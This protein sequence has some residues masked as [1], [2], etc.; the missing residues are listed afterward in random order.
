M[1]RLKG[2]VGL[3]AWGFFLRTFMRNRWCPPPL[4]K[5]D[6]GLTDD[7]QRVYDLLSTA[8]PMAA[9]ELQSDRVARDRV[10]LR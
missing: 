5:S 10:A 2:L 6:I 8:R 1:W 4:V 3:I 7:Q 9:G